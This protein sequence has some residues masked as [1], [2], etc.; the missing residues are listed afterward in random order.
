MFAPDLRSLKRK[1][2]KKASKGDDICC[3]LNPVNRFILPEKKRDF[4]EFELKLFSGRFYLFYC[5][6]SPAIL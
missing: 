1:D 3:S 6:P 4:Q 5:F 2:T